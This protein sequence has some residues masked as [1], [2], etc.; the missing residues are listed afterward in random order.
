MASGTPGAGGIGTVIDVLT[1]VVAR[2]TI[3]AHAMVA[4]Q[5]IQTCAPILAGVWHQVTFIDV[6]LAELTCPLRFALAVVSVHSIHTHT[7]ILTLVVCAVID[8]VFTVLAIETWQAG[9][10]VGGISFLHA[11]APIVAG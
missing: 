7:A 5:G 6:L 1:A 3:H 4:A 11:S 9:A 8:V 2:P 10:L